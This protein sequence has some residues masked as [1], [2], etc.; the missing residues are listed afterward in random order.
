MQNKTNFEKW[1]KDI[2]KKTGFKLGKNIYKGTYYSPGHIRNSICEGEYK[3]KPAILKIYDDPRTTD[4]PSA[5]KAF[6]KANTSKILTAPKLYAHKMLFV[7][8]G[9][10][11]EEKLPEGGH[12]FKSPLS[13]KEKNDFMRIYLEYRTNFP[14]EPTRERKLL[15]YLPAEEFHTIGIVKWLEL[16]SRKESERKFKNE[17]LVLKPEEFVKRYEKA[18]KFIR[19]EIM[20]RKMIWIHGHFKPNEIYKI[21]DDKYY[22][23]DFAHSK[24]APEGSELAFIIWSDHFMD[25]GDWNAPYEEWKKGISEWIEVF[26]EI[27]D[28]LKLKNYENLLR[29]NLLE[30]SLGTITADITASDR[31]YDEKIKRIDLLYKLIEDILKNKF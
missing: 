10:L 29:A 3:G 15:D 21:S 23:L 16:A 12:F 5:L 13:K 1:A 27:K 6:H 30:R 7:N 26:E 9:W 4:E 31:P 22:L 20:G 24:M 19:K 14:T 11:I 18:L 2:V 25:G 8:K 28:K 17:K